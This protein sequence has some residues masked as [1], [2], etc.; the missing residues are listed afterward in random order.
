MYE[1]TDDPFSRRLLL[2][3]IAAVIPA[4]NSERWIRR[5]LASLSGGSDRPDEMIVVDDAS[6]DGTGRE[7]RESGARV[8]ELDVRQG[9]ARARNAGAAA[10]SAEVILFV[11]SDV[12]VPPG[13]VER[14]RLAFEDPSVAAVQTIYTASCPATDLV[15]SYQNFYYHLA[16]ASIRG[17]RSAV[18][19]TWCAA[20]RKDVFESLGGFNEDIPDPTVEDEELGYAISDAGYAIL[21]ERDLQVTHLACYTIAAFARRRFRMAASQARSAWR[22][23]KNRLLLRYVNLRD[24]GTHHS[25]LTVLAILCMLAAQA[26]LI[27]WTASLIAGSERPALLQAAVVMS[28]AALFLCSRFLR[29]SVNSLGVNILAPFAALCLLDLLVLGWGIIWGTLGF[30]ARRRY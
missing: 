16:L 25:R 21:L 18:F 3:S 20:V 7:A 1:V 28:S 15:S 11:D 2:V 29:K 10:A 19:A 24:T 17:A 27:V 4:R 22:S 26:F 6:T 5:C 14:M 12:L 30:L 23:V 8:I 9:P 13:L